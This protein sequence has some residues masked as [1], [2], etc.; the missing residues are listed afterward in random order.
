PEENPNPVPGR[1]GAGALLYEDARALDQADA[2]VAQAGDRGAA[3]G[4]VE[5]RAQE[6]DPGAQ[7]LDHRV[8]WQGEGV[9]RGERALGQGEPATDYVAERVVGVGVRGREP[10]EAARHLAVESDGV[11]AIARAVVVVDVRPG[12][13]ARRHGLDLDRGMD[14]PKDAR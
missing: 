6:A 1:R 2:V 7:D 5:G 11:E 3:R 9:G 4:R 8:R 14:G 10:G 12:A 13:E